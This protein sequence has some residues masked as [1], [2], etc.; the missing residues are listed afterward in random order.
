[1]EAQLG[2][3]NVDVAQLV[4]GLKIP[5][6]FP[7]AGRISFNVQLAFPLDTP[8]DLKTYRLRGTASSPQLIV[9]G[10]EL[11]GLRARVAYS[12]GVL[13]L[14]EF[15]GRIPARASPG[16]GSKA[17]SFDGT[18][19]LE[20]I[21]EGD[22]TARLRL[23]AIPLDGALAF[24]PKAAEQARGAFSGNMDIRVPASKLKDL[25]AWNASGAITAERLDLYGLALEDVALSL[26][27]HQGN[28]SLQLTRGKLEETPLTA[29]AELH[30]ADPYPFTGKLSIPNADLAALQHL[31]PDVKP[32]V[33]IQGQLEVAGDITGSL[34]PFAF[35]TS[36][37]GTAKSLALD[38]LKIGALGFRWAGD[39][40]RIRVSDLQAH[41]YSG[42]LT[43]FAV[44][45]LRAASAGSIEVRIQNLDV[46][47]LSQDVP[48]LPVRLEGRA[49]GRLDGTL[50]GTEGAR[51]REFSSK[52][53]L[54]AP[55]LRVQGI[56]TERLNA[57]IN[58][59]NHVLTYQ[60]EGETLGGRFHLNGQIPAAKPM[61]TTPEAPEVISA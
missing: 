6:P 57:L 41:L 11:D 24:L 56:P 45:P 19:Q 38:Q 8:R 48:N 10:Q 20:V 32:P 37:H 58:Y 43:G 47:A 26:Q 54:Q 21:P 2:L 28:A 1:L 25:A 14:E 3:D 7:V 34:S 59:R 16:T 29:A 46:G 35:H 42:E 44:L 5:L 13:R 60:M 22:L 52:L 30:L 23:Q 18:A 15:R 36:G 17:G 12:N 53:E 55:Q 9:A 49:N 27:V 31:S 4:H 40:D 61:P 39:S 51:P 33:S 50:T